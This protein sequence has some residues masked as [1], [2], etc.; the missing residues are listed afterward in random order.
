MVADETDGRSLRVDV[1]TREYP[2]EVYGGAGVHAEYLAKYLAPLVDVH[3]RCFGGPRTVPAGEPPATGYAE[4]ADL[5]GANAAL[6]TSTR[7]HPNR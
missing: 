7:D 5:A 3:V 6:R 2:P 4:P 1:L